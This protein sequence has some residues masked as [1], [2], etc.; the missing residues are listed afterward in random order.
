MIY[1]LFCGNCE[2][3]NL[4][5]SEYPITGWD[6]TN[7]DNMSV[8]SLPTTDGTNLLTDVS[9]GEIIVPSSSDEVAGDI[10][11]GVEYGK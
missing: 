9:Y 10:V 2:T 8:T 7:C 4:V 5:D 3:E 6:C 11:M 1:S